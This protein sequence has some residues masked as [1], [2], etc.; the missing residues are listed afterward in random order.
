MRGMIGNMLICALI[1][2]QEG[3]SDIIWINQAG[4]LMKNKRSL[5]LPVLFL[6]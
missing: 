5:L 4:L 2:Y 1:I 3:I 6:V